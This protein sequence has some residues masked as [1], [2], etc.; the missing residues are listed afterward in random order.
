MNAAAHSQVL[1]HRHRHFEPLIRAALVG[2]LRQRYFFDR[3]QLFQ[4]MKAGTPVSQ[5]RLENQAARL[6]SL[7]VPQQP[8]G[9][10]VVD[11]QD[12]AGAKELLPPAAELVLRKCRVK[13]RGRRRMCCNAAWGIGC[14]CRRRQE[15]R[16]AV[17]RRCATQFTGAAVALDC[18]GRPGVASP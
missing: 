18:P 17:P 11:D 14:C 12:I 1:D 9:A 2:G 8:K 15:K 3:Q 10:L 4:R 13:V 6:N 16:A 5:D 7:D